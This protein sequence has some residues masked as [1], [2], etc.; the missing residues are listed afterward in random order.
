[1]SGGVS[2]GAYEAGYLY[3]FTE[4]IR[5][6][7]EL[8]DLKILTGASAGSVNAMIAIISLCSPEI[9]DAQRIA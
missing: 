2:L 4:M 1:M 7:R 8:L 3:Y 6:N 9:T 5:R